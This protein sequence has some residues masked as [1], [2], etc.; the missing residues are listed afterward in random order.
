VNLRPAR[1]EVIRVLSGKL[2]FADAPFFTRGD[3]SHLPDQDVFNIADNWP[4]DVLNG[5]RFKVNRMVPSGAPKSE[6][7]LAL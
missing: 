1:N 2:E 6:P 7:S 4:I 3:W 5:Q